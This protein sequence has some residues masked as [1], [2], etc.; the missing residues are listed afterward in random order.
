M[1]NIKGAGQPEYLTS[2][3]G[4]FTIELE[5]IRRLFEAD[6]S[7]I[8]EIAASQIQLLNIYHNVVLDQAKNSFRWALVAAAASEYLVPARARARPAPP[9][10]PAPVAKAD[11]ADALD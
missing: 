11:T 10:P 8:Q 4:L 7:K 5:P 6:P 3:D 2:S 1:D 9:P